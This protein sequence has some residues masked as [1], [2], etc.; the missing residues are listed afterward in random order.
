MLNR[1]REMEDAVVHFLATY[2]GIEIRLSTEEWDLIKE[3][4]VVFRPLYT[5]TLEMCGE[6][7][8]TISKVF[9]LSSRLITLYSKPNEKDSQQPKEVRK[10]I[11]ESL[12]KQFKDVESND[13]YTNATVFDPRFKTSFFKQYKKSSIINSAKSDVLEEA[14]AMAKDDVV[15]MEDE[16]EIDDTPTASDVSVKSRCVFFFPSIE[17]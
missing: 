17:C 16:D 4:T 13:L 7:F 11:Y 9:P 14:E 5:A 6:K 2:K 1:A 3:L 10:M 15:A 12:K 8:T